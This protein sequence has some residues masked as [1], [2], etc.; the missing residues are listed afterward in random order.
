[1]SKAINVKTRR[2]NAN[3]SQLINRNKVAG[4]LNQNRGAIIQHGG[5]N[6][7]ADAIVMGRCAPPAPA[8]RPL[9]TACFYSIVRLLDILFSPC[10]AADTGRTDLS[11][12]LFVWRVEKKKTPDKKSPEQIG[13]LCYKQRRWNAV[14][15]DNK[16]RT[17]FSFSFLIRFVDCF[18]SS[19]RSLR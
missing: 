6:S 9:T 12:R 7:S 14:I 8:P 2:N 5:C 11:Y 13:R 15:A 18:H 1:M 16:R 10:P 17:C 19:L 3:T 4:R